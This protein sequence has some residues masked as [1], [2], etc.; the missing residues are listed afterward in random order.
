MSSLVSSLSDTV[1]LSLAEAFSTPQPKAI[2]V[3][4]DDNNPLFNN[5]LFIDVDDVLL[6]SS[7][8]IQNNLVESLKMRNYLYPMKSLSGLIFAA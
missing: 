3:I 1:K 4:P 2:S 5:L 8:K 7:A 6:I